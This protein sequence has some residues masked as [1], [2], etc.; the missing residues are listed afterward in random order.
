MDLDNLELESREL[1]A[2]VSLIDTYGNIDGAHHKQWVLDKCMR[3]ALRHRY[4]EWV[5]QRKEEG[6]DWDEGIPP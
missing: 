4:S 1:A 2:I 3:I 5:R 6:Y